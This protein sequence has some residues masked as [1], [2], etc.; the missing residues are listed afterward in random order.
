MANREV[1]QALIEQL[2]QATQSF[3]PVTDE[4]VNLVNKLDQDCATTSK[5][6]KV[7]KAERASLLEMIKSSD[8]LENKVAYYANHAADELIKEANTNQVFKLKGAIKAENKVNVAQIDPKYQLILTLNLVNLNDEQILPY[9]QQSMAIMHKC[10]QETATLIDILS[11]SFNNA[12][13]VVSNVE[14]ISTMK[15]FEELCK[16]MGNFNSI[17]KFNLEKAEPKLN[18]AAAS[19]D[20]NNLA[21]LKTIIALALTNAIRSRALYL[22]L[23]KV[24]VLSLSNQIK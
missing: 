9:A 12:Q 1:F 13:K 3:A 11:A 5:V 15:D 22:S 7:L 14:E 23:I 24:F 20:A 8:L 16:V 10:H 21:T 6:N 2:N 17:L 19:L 18:E 4:I